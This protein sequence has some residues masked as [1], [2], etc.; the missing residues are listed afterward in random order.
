MAILPEATRLIVKQLAPEAFAAHSQQI[1]G[2]TT[3][4]RSTEL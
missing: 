2:T 4:P 1:H 3:P